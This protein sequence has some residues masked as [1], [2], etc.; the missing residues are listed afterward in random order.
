MVTCQGLSP[1]P[2]RRRVAGCRRVPRRRVHRSQPLMKPRESETVSEVTVAV[3]RR[4]AEGVTLSQRFAEV[5][6]IAQ[7]VGAGQHSG[8]AQ[9]ARGY[10]PIRKA[11]AGT[12]PASSERAHT[13]HT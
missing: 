12:V 11:R 3:P 6:A 2:F 4:T 5:H 8:N 7:D 1:L 13:A 9:Q 10:T